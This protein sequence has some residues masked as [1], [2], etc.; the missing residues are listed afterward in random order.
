MSPGDIIHVK[1]PVLFSMRVLHHYFL[2]KRTRLFD[3]FASENSGLMA[4]AEHDIRQVFDIQPTPSTKQLMAAKGFLFKPHP[5]GFTVIGQGDAAQPIE[6]GQRL[7]DTERLEFSLKIVDPHFLQYSAHFSQLQSVRIEKAVQPD[8]QDRFFKR[9]YHFDN[10]A[11]THMP[12]LA[13]GPANYDNN[14]PYSTEEMVRSVSGGMVAFHQA[15]ESMA[16]GV[17]LGS[18]NWNLL[19]TRDYALYNANLE[20]TTGQRVR[21]SGSLGHFEAKQSVPTNTPPQTPENAFWRKL[22]DLNVYYATAADLGAE[23]ELKGEYPADAFALISIAGGHQPDEF[24][25]YD[26]TFHLRS[27]KYELR[28]QNRW[29]W[30]HYLNV[31]NGSPAIPDDY[32]PI[33]LRGKVAGREAVPNPDGKTRLRREP[34]DVSQPLTRLFSDI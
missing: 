16:A 25:L 8:K 15:K 5:F 4:L 3:N 13:K 7:S 12:F 27:P 9:F 28:F 21:A 29:S 11:A 1:Y 18:A 2:D 30:W 23:L 22:N 32:F 17:A 24:S 14:R 33:T 34:Q 26:A 20:Y 10:R 31:P 6:E 19:P